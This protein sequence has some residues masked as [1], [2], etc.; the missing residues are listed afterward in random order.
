MKRNRTLRVGQ[1]K[2]GEITLLGMPGDSY[3]SVRLSYDAFIFTT[4]ALRCLDMWWLAFALWLVCIIE[5]SGSLGCIAS[6]TN[7][8]NL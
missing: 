4:K 3:R 2:L 5:V 8:R 1:Y 7:P 6:R